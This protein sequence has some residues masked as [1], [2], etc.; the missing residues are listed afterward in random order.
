MS[1]T[2]YRPTGYHSVTAYLIFDDCKAAIAFYERAFNAVKVLQLDMG[3][4]VGHAEITIGDSHLMMADVAAS[5]DLKS[6]QGLGAS[7]VSFMIY[8]PDVDAAFA[9]ALKAGATE[10][11]PVEDQFY[12]DRTGTLEDPFGYSW[13]LATHK[14]VVT[15]AEV[16]A[17]LDKMMGG[18]H[19]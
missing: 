6:A 5:G 16:Q 2:P 3:S 14:E 4:V 18:E 9:Q 19:A 7:P 1:T 15:Q 8:V 11:K 13:T 10:R 17:R 12:G